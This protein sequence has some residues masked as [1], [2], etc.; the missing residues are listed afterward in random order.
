[1]VYEYEI[2]LTIPFVPSV[3]PHTLHHNINMGELNDLNK[4]SMTINCASVI[5][6]K[7]LKATLWSLE[8]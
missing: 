6:E 2:E 5:L 4:V 1:M 3:F 8:C 7:A